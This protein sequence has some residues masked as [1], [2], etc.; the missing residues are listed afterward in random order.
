MSLSSIQLWCNPKLIK[1][2]ASLKLW[3]A[4][5]M[6]GGQPVLLTRFF[7]NKPYFYFVEF[8]K[9]YL[10]IFDSLYLLI[11]VLLGG[12]SLWRKKGKK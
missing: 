10:S 1:M 7:H 12:F 6:D 11:L 8:L 4:I 3:E 5:T 9:C 2:D